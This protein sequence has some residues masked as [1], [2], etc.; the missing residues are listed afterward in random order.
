MLWIN[1]QLSTLPTIT[2]LFLPS[3]VCL[4]AS[5]AWL[6]RQVDD[7]NSLAESSVPEGTSLPQYGALV[8]WSGIASLLSVPV[9]TELSGLPPYLAMLTGLGAIWTLTDVIHMGGH[10]G[11]EEALTVPA[12]L[13][14]LDTAGILVSLVHILRR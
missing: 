14:R 9:F 8:F 2:E 10:E 12:A 13:A 4:V 3:I 7:D 11:E 6:V 5:L 1:N